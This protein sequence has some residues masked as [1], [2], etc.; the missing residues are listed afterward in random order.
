MIKR[1][2][3]GLLF[4]II[5][6]N[7]HGDIYMKSNYVYAI[8]L[9]ITLNTMPGCKAKCSRHCKVEDFQNKGIIAIDIG[10]RLLFCLFQKIN[11]VS[12][13]FR[14]YLLS[15]STDVEVINVLNQLWPFV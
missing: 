11:V 5:S 6:S 15:M 1:W 13:I 2:D 14:L 4:P 8:Y 9:N 7:L 3:L 10:Y 12:V